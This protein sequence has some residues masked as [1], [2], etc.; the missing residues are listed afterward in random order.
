MGSP[1]ALLPWG[2]VTALEHL[3]TVWAA[4]GASQIAVVHDPRH[5]PIMA[6]IDRLDGVAGIANPAADEGMMSSVRAASA[7]KGWKVDKIALSLVDQPWVGGELIHALAEFSTRGIWQ[8][9]FDGRKGHPVFFQR[10]LFLRISEDED[11]T[12]KDFIDR[13]E[14]ERSF[15]PWSNGDVLRDMDTPGDYRRAVG[16][17]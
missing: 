5:G 7:W 3:V 11:A 6:E 1:K 14:R 9:V 16:G 17:M 15:L 8:P 10:E 4:A 13:H 12:L 2:E